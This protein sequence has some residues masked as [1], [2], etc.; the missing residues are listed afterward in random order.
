MHAAV[1]VGGGISGLAT[2]Y[3]LQRG[4]GPDASVRVLEA[5]PEIGGK[6]RTR[7]LAGLPVDTGPD[8]FL[9]RSPELRE[10]VADLGLADA[11]VEPL[12]GGSYIWA[13]GRLRPLP[14]GMAFGLPERLLPLLRSGLLTP[15]A[16]LRAGLDLVLPATRTTSDPTVA[17]LV[18]PRFGTGVYDQLV[19]P[20][21]GGVHAGDAARL[22]AHSAVP[23]VAAMAGSGRSMYLAMRRRRRAAP[24]PAPGARP[25][26]PL[27]SLTGGLSTLT[28]ALA[29]RVH[30]EVHS[31]VRHLERLPLGG[32]RVVTD[33]M[34]YDAA[35]VVLATP[36][37][38]SAGLLSELAP[39]AAGT[40]TEIPYVDV[41]NVTLAFRP[42]DVPDLPPGTGFLVPPRAGELVVGCTWLTQKWPDLADRGVVL[43]KTMVGRAGD[44]RWEAMSDDELV[45][46]VRDGLA[47]MLGLTADPVDRLVQRWPAAM[48]QYV[49][50]HADRL[51]RLDAALADLP[52]LVVTGAAYRGIGLAGCVAQARATARG[53]AHLGD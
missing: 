45:A 5:G 32:Y 1:V 3:F 19:A 27:V 9:S 50:G 17:E 34:E 21:L 28:A 24:A 16:T 47:R 38:V 46:G 36:A 33:A 23:E 53:L 51:A 48:P 25:A 42:D 8:A 35:R 2:G 40:L 52:G 7:L 43:V 13:R 39:A 29:E 12:P 49:V 30:V 22:S 18:R 26:A 11:V 44:N 6:V 31:A 20:L 15:A 10:L 41:A 37:Y 14:P 4:L